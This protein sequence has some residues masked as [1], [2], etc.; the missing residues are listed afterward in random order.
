MWRL[1]GPEGLPALHTV[2]G[3]PH[4]VY[5]ALLGARDVFGDLDD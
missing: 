3:L 2:Q 4:A 1:S 5:A